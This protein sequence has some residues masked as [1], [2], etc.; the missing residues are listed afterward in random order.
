MTREP[1]ENKSVSIKGR[2]RRTWFPFFSRFGGLTSIQQQAIPL[3]LDDQNVVMISPAASG[4]TEAALAPLCERMIEKGKDELAILYISPTRALVNDLYRRLENPLQ[5][6]ACSLAIKTGDRPKLDFEKLPFLLITTP[7]SFDSLLSRH[8]GIFEKLGAVVL[9]ELHLIDRTPRGDQVRILLERLRRINS[10]LQY[11]ALSA[12]IDDRLIGGRYFA[13]ARTVIGQQTREIDCRLLKKEET[14]VKDLF[15]IIR[16]RGLRK[17]LVFFNSRS[18]AEQYGRDFNRP[19]FEGRVLVHHASLTRERRESIERAMNQ[20]KAALLCATTTLELGIDI[21]DIDGVVLFR[22][23][24]SV[25]SLLQRIG[26]G[27]RRN[28]DRLFAV[29]VY[30]N[31]WERLLF[32]LSFE[33]ARSGQLLEK[34]YRPSR[35][36]I[37]QQTYSYLL[38]RR[39]LGTTKR[40]MRGILKPI[41]DETAGFDRAFSFLVENEYI[42]SDAGGVY[43][44]GP[45]LERV[46]ARGKVHSNI[47]E[48]SFGFYQVFDAATG[49][50]IGQIFYL[51]ERIFLA[52]RSWRV[53]AADKKS[54]RVMVELLAES[55]GSVKLFEGTGTGGYSL[56]FAGL[57][58]QR[59]FPQLA[60][61]VFPYFQEWGQTCVF[62]F[63]NPVIGY[64]LAQGLQEKEMD[65]IDVQG[66]MLVIRGRHGVGPRFPVPTARDFKKVIANNLLRLED[67]LGS[68][69]FYRHLPRELQV[70]DHYQTLNIDGL[71]R[72]LARARLEEID[73]GLGQSVAERI[74]E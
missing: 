72:H 36:V 1:A 10:G 45:K 50:K 65:A 47:Q 33:C 17:V 7:E 15:S 42:K 3:I 40:L 74:R 22:P 58:K 53:L 61:E 28:A 60:P 49:Q 48:K 31:D 73:P 30:L 67:G 62:H 21:G 39:R 13:N 43:F 4:K 6:L 5:M 38:Q 69:A 11:C 18:H 59:L 56:G 63:L 25:S 37:P 46:V 12:T 55:D 27:N 9:D 44:L 2:L 8:A 41:I 64:M 66:K 29:G 34:E 24:Y 19:P 51:F 32:E 16:E 14:F 71:L 35:S 54:G 68:G 57:V 23:P 52:G 20:E 70:E 26:R